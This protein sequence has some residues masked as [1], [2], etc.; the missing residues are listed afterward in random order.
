MQI[1]PETKTI[2]ELA[3]EVVNAIPVLERMNIDYCCR[4]GRS[5]AEACRD[6]GVT[7]TELMSTLGEPR[8]SGDMAWQT[9]SLSELQRHIID[10]HH[11][12]TR[13]AIETI[14]LLADKVAN[15]HGANHP[16]VIDVHRLAFA[17]ANDVL[18]HMMKE[19]EILFPYVE[20]LERNGSESLPGS[21]FGTI[22]NPIRVMMLEHEGVGAILADLR[23][24]TGGYALPDDACL[25][26]RALYERLADLEQDLHKHI[27]LENNLHFPRALKLEE[28]LAEVVR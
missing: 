15:R 16:E 19:E 8:V 9:R 18:P 13:Q 10:T 11:V 7:F 1:N 26:F 25:S 24:V 21:C 27:H 5:I 22:A 28:S 12:Y 20:Q 4:G 14:T 17:L 23:R 6:A 3:L 2:G